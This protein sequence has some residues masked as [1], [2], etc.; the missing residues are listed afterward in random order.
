MTKDE[1]VSLIE[2]IYNLLVSSNADTL[3]EISS[4]KVRFVMSI[5]RSNSEDKKNI[6]NGIR[7]LISEKYTNEKQKSKKSAK[8][9]YEKEKDFLDDAY[10]IEKA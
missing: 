1:V 6:W 8:A 5:L 3:S 4:E 2:S 10:L 7:R 9:Q